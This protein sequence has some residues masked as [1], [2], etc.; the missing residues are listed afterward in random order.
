MFGANCSLLTLIRFNPVTFTYCGMTPESPW[1]SCNTHTADHS[2]PAQTHK[3]AHGSRIP[4]LVLAPR[5]NNP[6]LVYNEAA[7]N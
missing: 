4:L 7:G 5:C 3:R 2:Y 6:C 1:I